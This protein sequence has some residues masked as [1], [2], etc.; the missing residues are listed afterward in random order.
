MQACRKDTIGGGVLWIVAVLSFATIRE[1]P[2]V[3]EGGGNALMV[4]LRQ[5]QLLVDDVPF[6]RFVLARALLLAVA[7]APP[8][9]VLIAQEHAQP[10]LLGLGALIIANGLA[11]SVSAP[12]THC[13]ARSGRVYRVALGPGARRSAGYASAPGLWGVL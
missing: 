5:L 2:G 3:T 13:C 7:L 1:Q 9:Y 4:A 12:F 8:F 6:R 11:A 10:G